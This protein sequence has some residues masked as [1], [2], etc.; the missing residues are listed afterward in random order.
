MTRPSY[1]MGAHVHSVIHRPTDYTDG[2]N[3]CNYLKAHMEGKKG[4]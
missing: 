4:I 2:R 1:G 3:L